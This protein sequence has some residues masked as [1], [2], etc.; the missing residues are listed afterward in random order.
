MD[1]RPQFVV[2]LPGAQINLR[3]A[4]EAAEQAVV[5]PGA[6]H[7]VA[8]VF[9]RGQA[10]LYLDGEL[11]G[12]AEAPPEKAFEANDL[13]LFVGGNAIWDGTVEFAF[14]GDIDELRISTVARYQG[15]AF[16]P[17][18]RFEPDEATALLLH[19]DGAGGP[20]ARDAG[21]SRRHGLAIGDVRYV[22]P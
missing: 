8:A 19:L 7:H 21:D 18:R 22:A 17:V 6:W 15:D 1:G 2:G 13:P 4:D 20:F 11:V 3:P 9:D 16:A 5:E 14:E 10:R 12:R